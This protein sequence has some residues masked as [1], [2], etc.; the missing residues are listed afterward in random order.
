M[1]LFYIVNFLII[2]N[3]R[4]AITR[5]VFRSIPSFVRSKEGV[6]Y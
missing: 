3:V 5:K 6:F 1:F 4:S 2:K